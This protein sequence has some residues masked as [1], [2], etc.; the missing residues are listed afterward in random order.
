[1]FNEATFGKILLPSSS[2]V[3][4]YVASLEVLSVL[5]SGN[6]SNYSVPF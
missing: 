6:V 2:N 5:S 3:N 1:M 4:D